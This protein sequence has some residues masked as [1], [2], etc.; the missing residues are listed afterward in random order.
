MD[1]LVGLEPGA[2]GKNL[3]DCDKKLTLGISNYNLDKRTKNPE[4]GHT[5]LLLTCDCSATKF[6][7]A[8]SD[9]CADVAALCAAHI[10]GMPRAWDPKAEG[11]R[12]ESILL[13]LLHLQ[14][15]HHVRRLRL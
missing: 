8:I 13:R 2:F 14:K 11:P 5:S 15:D 6:S 7:M 1:S 9:S 4:G 10:V 12:Q 3:C